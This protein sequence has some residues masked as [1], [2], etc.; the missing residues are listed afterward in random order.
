[1]SRMLQ[2]YPEQHIF[3]AIILNIKNWFNIMKKIS[4]ESFKSLIKRD[5]KLWNSEKI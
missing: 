1:M 5:K 2:K 3:D 4:V